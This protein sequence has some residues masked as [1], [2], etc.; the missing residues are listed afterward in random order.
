MTP[1]DEDRRRRRRERNKIAATKCRMK[2]RERTINL[3]SEAETLDTQNGDMKKQVNTLELECRALTDMLRAHAPACM[4]PDNLQLPAFPS[5]IAKYLNTIST[6]SSSSNN[7]GLSVRDTCDSLKSKISVKISQP[8][9]VQKIPSVN[10]LKFGARR[11][12]S[13]RQNCQI[14]SIPTTTATTKTAICIQTAATNNRK[15]LPSIDMGFCEGNGEFI[16]P[17]YCPTSEC[18]TINSPDSGFIKSPVDIAGNYTNL[19]T[20]IIKTDYIPNCDASDIGLVENNNDDGTIELIFKSEMVD[21]S[22]NPY[23]T[24]QSAD[25]FLCDGATE[26]FD[27]DLDAPVVVTTAHHL[28]DNGN[29][30]VN[31]TTMTINHDMNM[32]P[33]KEHLLMQNNNNSSNNNHNLQSH[34]MNMCNGDSTTNGNMTSAISTHS[35]I[36]FNQTCQQF[37]DMRGDF[38]NQNGEFLTLA[39]DN[40]DTQ[41]TDLDSGVTTYTNVTNGSGCLA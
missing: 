23:T 3:V 19:Q 26:A 31:H 30:L 39:G 15:P 38:L 12:Q 35:I 34:L 20:A 25:R 8:Q 16:G 33:L 4:N 37:M 7:S 21:S 28:P 14:V 36:E 40:C 2:K 1:E 5:H 27:S 10:T 13:H 9:K 32:T 24:A 22:D 18:F 17:V 6:E 29:G 41:F 11:T